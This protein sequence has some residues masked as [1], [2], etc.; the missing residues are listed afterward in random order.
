MPTTIKIAV[1]AQM[2]TLEMQPNSFTNDKM[3]FT[4]PFGRMDGFGI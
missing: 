4:Y 3:K 1:Q 2:H